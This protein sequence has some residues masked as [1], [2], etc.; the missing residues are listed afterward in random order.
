VRA[1]PLLAHFSVASLALCLGLGAA[2]Q[3][4]KPGQA[5]PQTAQAP[6]NP[7]TEEQIRTYFP[8]CH[9]P[10]VS[11]QLTHE[12]MEQ[13]RKQL[14]QWYPQPV[15]DEVED[16]ID[17]IDLPK[18]AL[19]VYQNYI[20]ADDAAFLIHFFAS[21]QGQKM[22]RSV[23][24]KDTQEQHAGVAPMEARQLAIAK[25]A[26][27]EGREVDRVVGSM[28]PKQLRELDARAGYLKTMQPVLAKMQQEYSQALKDQQVEAARAVVAKHQSEMSAAKRDYE[29]GHAPK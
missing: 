27:D 12:K 25:I 22:V 8:V 11:R 4:Q 23:M 14:P 1:H 5:A 21:P 2:A 20:S 13:Q 26:S 29:S 18:V 9:I 3:Q 28:S 16:A 10:S 24:T 6:T 19:P 7:I 17:S 15:W